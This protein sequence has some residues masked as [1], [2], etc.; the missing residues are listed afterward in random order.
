[1]HEGLELVFLDAHDWP[2]RKEDVVIMKVD[3]SAFMRAKHIQGEY[4]GNTIGCSLS[5]PPRHERSERAVDHTRPYQSYDV[6]E[7]DANA[8]ATR[9]ATESP[10]LMLPPEIRIQIYN[11][12]LGGHVIH[13]SSTVRRSIS[14]RIGQERAFSRDR[15]LHFTS[16]KRDVKPSCWSRLGHIFSAH[17]TNLAAPPK[18]IPLFLICRQITT[19]A[20]DIFHTENIFELQ[21]PYFTYPGSDRVLSAAQHRYTIQPQPDLHLIFTLLRRIYMSLNT[22]EDFRNP[23]H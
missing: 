2:E 15:E 21:M 9:N 13:V 14:G 23:V 10:F 20:L 12:F 5:K 7:E 19:E 18:T 11:L 17:A 16:P 22:L 6:R 3:P 4:R 8:I 1:M